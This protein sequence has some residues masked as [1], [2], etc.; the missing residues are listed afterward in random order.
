[1]HEED[2]RAWVAALINSVSHGDLIRV[3]VMMWA[4]WY[5][6]RK[7]THENIFQG[8][9]STHSFVNNY[10]SDLLASKPPRAVKASV[11]TRHPKWLPP[12]AGCTKVNVD[13]AISKNLGRASMAVVARDQVGMFF[14]ASGVVLKV[15]LM[16]GYCMPER[17]TAP[18]V[19]TSNLLC[20]NSVVSER[21]MATT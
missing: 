7:A 9:L 6:R 19:Q 21:S 8:P 3:V 2:A 14:G 11:Q 4:I 16:L 10:V 1:M 15:L 20:S 17:F 12:P 5:A 13:A 18:P